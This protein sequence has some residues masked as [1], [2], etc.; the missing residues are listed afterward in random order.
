MPLIN[1]SLPNLLQGVS[2]QPSPLKFS[3]QCKEQVNLHPSVVNGLTRRPSSE[4]QFALKESGINI[5]GLPEGSFVHY[6]TTRAK[7]NYVLVHT[8]TDLYVYNLADGTLA[9]IIVGG[10]G[11]GSYNIP[12]GHYLDTGDFDPIDALRVLT[13]GDTTF[14]VNRNVGVTLDTTE[15][16]P[17]LE[18]EAVIF[19]KQG[20]YDKKYEVVIKGNFSGSETAGTTATC[21][22]TWDYYNHFRGRSFW[23]VTGVTMGVKG[24][25]YRDEDVVLTFS[26]PSE[27]VW[28]MPR[29]KAVVNPADGSITSV[30]VEE[31]GKIERKGLSPPTPS[32]TLT[33]NRPTLLAAGTGVFTSTITSG[34][35]SAATNADT[36]TITGQLRTQI[37]SV[38]T[39]GGTAGQHG[40]IIIFTKDLYDGAI[41]DFDIRTSDGLGDRGLGVVY[42]KVESL[43][44]L[45]TFCKNGFRVEIEGDVE[46]NVDN[47]WVQFETKGGLADVG[48]GTWVEC[49]AP[50]SLIRINQDT[51]PHLLSL[52][53]L[54]EFTLSEMPV[55]ERQTGDDDTNPFPSFVGE[56][57]KTVFFFKDRLGFASLNSVSLSE[58]GIGPIE[59]GILNYNWFR[60]TVS[61]LLDSAPIDVQVTSKRVTEIEHA[62]TTQDRLF[63]IA[64]GQ[65]FVLKGGDILSPSTVEVSPV[66]NYA[67]DTDIPPIA[68]GRNVLFGF[69]RGEFA[70]IREMEIDV[71]SDTYLG[72]EIT[73]QIP[74]YLPKNI[75]LSASTDAENISMFGSIE[76]AHRLYA[77]T[78]LWENNQKIL[79]SWGKHEVPFEVRGMQFVDSNLYLLG[80]NVTLVDKGTDVNDG[81]YQS[82][83]GDEFFIQVP[84]TGAHGLTTSDYV[85]LK[86]YRFRTISYD[87]V[88]LEFVIKP[89]EEYTGLSKF[90]VDAV[91]DAESIQIV[92]PRSMCVQSVAT[93][94]PYSSNKV[95][96]KSYE[97]HCMKINFESGFVDTIGFNFHLDMRFKTSLGY[98]HNTITS[99]YSENAF[100]NVKV[101]NRNTGKEYPVASVSGTTIT[102]SST[103]NEDHLELYVG[104]EFS[105]EYTFSEQLFKQA[106]GGNK[107]PV[108]SAQQRIRRGR[109]YMTDT[110]SFDIEVSAPN[111]NIATTSFDPSIVRGAQ[112]YG[113]SDLVYLNSGSVNFPVA[114]RGEDTD[115]KVVTSGALPLNLQSA[116]FEVMVAG[117][118]QRDGS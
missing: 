47:Y 45:P 29:F 43:S 93:G 59:N 25:G 51:M 94:L 4:W 35:S 80:N 107:T 38:I 8:G 105:S 65:Q 6:I 112:S 52:T 81:T 116:E 82:W 16:T 12:D 70:G 10:S 5:G 3:G 86:D 79:N 55:S 60:A 114:Q 103:S 87:L 19:I 37:A 54:N 44:D 64:D 113:E 69:N 104:L 97:S 88:D 96:T 24:S 50:N 106:Q 53:D 68:T 1:Y 108:Q 32:A 2:Q 49:P 17:E 71:D 90:A 61:S 78:F 73:Q 13:V 7:E 11:T 118:S 115:I 75:K 26:E 77:N 63:L 98:G 56:T 9:D 67:V 41:D 33:F 66:T 15:Y 101:F 109:L 84:F 76:D 23:Y 83:I 57:I 21:T 95:Y 36:V 117:K 99:P 102:L 14:L 34:P 40:N 89:N 74:K 58:A 48:E 92:V 62:E 30:T 110:D 46:E 18:K 31:R 20:D 42:K 22:L 85:Y 39:S 28:T 100:K 91:V 27:A 111:R 72:S